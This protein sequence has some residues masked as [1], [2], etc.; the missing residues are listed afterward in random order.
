MGAGRAAGQDPHE[1]LRPGACAHGRPQLSD[2]PSRP[3]LALA[4]PPLS[5]AGCPHGSSPRCGERRGLA[6]YIYGYNQAYTDAGTLFAQG[7]VDIN[8]I[9]DAV[10]T[11]VGEF[12][13]IA[14]ELLERDELEKARNFAKGRLCSRWRTRRG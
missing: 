1:D 7:G 10:A 12:G 9:D 11:I 13:R 8:R 4:L 5:A 14:A 6:Y 2:R 3:V